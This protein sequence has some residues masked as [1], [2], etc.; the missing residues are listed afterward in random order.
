MKHVAE[1]NAEV[2]AVFSRWNISQ[3]DYSVHAGFNESLIRLGVGYVQE[4]HI[5]TSAEISADSPL[6]SELGNLFSP[7]PG[8]LFTKSS[9]LRTPVFKD[10]GSTWDFDELVLSRARPYAIHPSGKTSS[11]DI[12]PHVHS[13][14]NDAAGSSSSGGSANRGM[15]SGDNGR[16][17]G[18]GYGGKRPQEGQDRDDNSQNGDPDKENPDDDDSNEPNPDGQASISFP[19]VSFDVLAN[20]YCSG[21]DS[22]S[23]ILFQELQINGTLTLQVSF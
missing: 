3:S 10:D 19:H 2:K 8:I 21:S 4:I 18:S 14:L 12:V 20:V 17:K 15:S 1:R 11:E 16:N 22:A 13:T 6:V 7:Y 5:F 9:S 23:S